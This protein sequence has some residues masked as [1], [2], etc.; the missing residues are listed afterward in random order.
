M[1]WD[2]IEG[3]WKQFKGKISSHWGKLESSSLT[4][5]R[6]AKRGPA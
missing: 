5:V 1:N 4:A 6:Q 3:N 2:E